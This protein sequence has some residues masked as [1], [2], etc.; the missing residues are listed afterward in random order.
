MPISSAIPCIKGESWLGVEVIAKEPSDL[1]INQAQPDPKR[2]NAAFANCS[3]SASRLPKWEFI[4]SANESLGI[5]PPEGL[6][7]S[8]KKCG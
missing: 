8:Q 2:V 4:E 3:L 6:S 1:L 7:V 5:P